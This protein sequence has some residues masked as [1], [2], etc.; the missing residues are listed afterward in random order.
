MSTITIRLHKVKSLDGNWLLGVK[1]KLDKE[2]GYFI[3]DTGAQVNM[4]ECKFAKHLLLTEKRLPDVEIVGISP[5][6]EVEFTMA[7]K[8][9]IYL[10]RYS[11]TLN[12][13]M[14]M[15][16]SH[17]RAKFNKKYNVLGLMGN[18]F[19]FKHKAKVNYEE[20]I[21]EILKLK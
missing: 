16:L 15:D 20:M 13:V 19:L 2:T 4:V 5:D 11:L 8:V 10:S 1:G 7:E 17:I 18:N 3:L 21:L 12:D 6:G 9:P 14:V